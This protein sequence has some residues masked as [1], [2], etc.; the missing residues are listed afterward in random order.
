[1]GYKKTKTPWSKR[2]Q[3]YFAFGVAKYF[4]ASIQE[5]E[6]AFSVLPAC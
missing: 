2:N 5:G 6:I 4:S 3:D 1:M